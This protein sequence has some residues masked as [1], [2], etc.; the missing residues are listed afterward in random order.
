MQKLDD[1]KLYGRAKGFPIILD[2]GA[3]FLCDFVATQK[4]KTILEIGTAI[5]YSGS[6]MLLNCDAKLT[7]IEINEDTAQIA[8]T[9][10][11]QM[12]LTDRVQVIVGDA[13]NVLMTLDN[14]YDMIFLDGPKG[15]YIKY[16]PTL[17]TL[18]NKSGYLVADNVLFRGMVL[19]GRPVEKRYKTLVNNLKHYLEEINEYTKNKVVESELLHISDGISVVK[20]N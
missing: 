7:T 1:I 2:E 11:E 9:N 6:L 16:L 3:N 8:K 17:L 10:F 18:L 20:M 15:Q 4:P 19:D 5:G 13:G 12:E 14:K